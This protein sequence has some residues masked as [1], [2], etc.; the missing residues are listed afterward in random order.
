MPWRRR[1]PQKVRSRSLQPH[2]RT[3]D[4]FPWMRARDRSIPKQEHI[5]HGTM[6]EPIRPWTEEVIA[7][8]RTEIHRK[9]IEREELEK[10]LLKASHIERKQILREHIQKIDLRSVQQYFGRAELSEI[11]GI[12]EHELEHLEKVQH[13]EDLTILELTRQIDELTKR[14]T[15]Q[16]AKIENTKQDQV[17]FK[18][19]ITDVEDTIVL[20]LDKNEFDVKRIEDIQRENLQHLEDSNILKLDRSQEIEQKQMKQEIPVNWRRDRKQKQTA[21]S[22]VTRHSDDTNILLAEEILKE[23]AVQWRRGRKTEKEKEIIATELSHIEDTNILH[24]NRET[25]IET[26]QTKENFKPVVRQREDKKVQDTFVREESHLEDTLISTIDQQESTE[27]QLKE[28]PTMWRRGRKQQEIVTLE[29]DTTEQNNVIQESTVPWLRGKQKKVEKVEL[30]ETV[31]LKPTRK[32]QNISANETAEP[33]EESVKIETADTYQSEEEL[34]EQPVAWR[35]TKK[36]EPVEEK[37]LPIEKQMPTEIHKTDEELIDQLVAWRRTKK[38]EPKVEEKQLPIENQ[39][40]TEKVTLQ[41]EQPEELQPVEE[42]IMQRKLPTSN[43]VV[44]QQKEAIK[45]RK[46][47]PKES[48]TVQE[49]EPI[50]EV[51]EQRETSEEKILAPTNKITKTKKLVISKDSVET[52]NTEEVIDEKPTQEI[53]ELIDVKPQPKD[54]ETPE[55]VIAEKTEEIIKEKSKKTKKIVKKKTK[56]EKP[57]KQ[58]SQDEIDDTEEIFEEIMPVESLVKPT[59]EEHTVDEIEIID[60]DIIEEIVEDSTDKDT[61]AETQPTFTVKQ[62]DTTKKKTKKLKQ[63]VFS[64]ELQ[65]FEAETVEDESLD[66]EISRSSIQLK[67]SDNKP[68][69]AL[70]TEY[71]EEEFEYDSDFRKEITYKIM[72]NITKINRQV[73]FIGDEGQLLPELELITQKRIQEAL[74]RREEITDKVIQEIQDELL[75]N[76][77]DNKLTKAPKFVKKLKPEKSQ[78]NKSTVLQC[79]VDGVPFP[80][81]KWYFNDVELFATEN[82][83]M[84]VVE[85]TATLEIVNVEPKHVGIYTCQAKNK[86]GVATTKANIVMGK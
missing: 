85:E 27:E 36:I 81:I 83:I 3:I 66:E 16:K 8:K 11:L 37:L 24:V 21:S 48:Q 12:Q 46:P 23:E 1:R 62:K 34:K 53:I 6:R 52:L 78:P 2:E 17:V 28:V 43:D 45:K 60:S 13:E 10:V 64:D 38:V 76:V 50:T 80:E 14:D 18:E 84:K 70:R 39:L 71:H 57:H 22:H 32:F 63:V 72:S 47:A 58:I 7:L 68:D 30:L 19:T 73:R 29:V 20:K 49:K 4:D 40:P 44:P 65:T 15:K 67:L 33:L 25:Q 42:T 77:R 69:A 5:L 35:R 41:H 74:E 86:A 75:S 54:E 61:S 56:E 9:I 51:I 26:K 31:Q 59:K 79:K 55:K 82:I